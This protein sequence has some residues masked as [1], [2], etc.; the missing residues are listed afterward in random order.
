MSKFTDHEGVVLRLTEYG[1]GVVEDN[2]SREQFTFTFDKIRGYRG[3]EPKELGLH[4]GSRIWF[5]ATVDTGV[6]VSVRLNK[7]P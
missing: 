5:S 3:E 4:V 7:P 6:I 1:L 2:A